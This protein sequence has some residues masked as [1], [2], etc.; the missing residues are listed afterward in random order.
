MSTKSP[1]FPVS[2]CVWFGF[3]SRR[4]VSSFLCFIVVAATFVACEL[5][6]VKPSTSAPRGADSSQ[7]F[8][9]ACSERERAIDDWE[10]RKGEAVA[11]DFIDGKITLLRAGLEA[12]R[13][14]EEADAMRRKLRDNCE[15][16]AAA[17][18][19]R[20][21]SSRSSSFQALVS[22]STPEPS[23]TP[24]LA[25]IP[26]RTPTPMERANLNAAECIASGRTVDGDKN[27]EIIVEQSGAAFVKAGWYSDPSG[28]ER[29]SGG[30]I[31]VPPETPKYYRYWKYEPDLASGTFTCQETSFREYPHT[32]VLA[33]P[34]DPARVNEVAG[35][36]DEICRHWIKSWHDGETFLDTRS[37]KY[38]NS[39]GQGIRRQFSVTQTRP[40]DERFALV[41]AE[42]KYRFQLAPRPIG[43]R[44]T[45]GDWRT[46]PIYMVYDLSDNTCR[47]T[48]HSATV[49]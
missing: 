41:L 21:Q 46:E 44:A 22:T 48:E 42:H 11:E 12:E 17:D 7:E 6:P 28:A 26:T 9:E 20:W 34:G 16:K 10:E 33:A 25:P 38:Q 43:G 39:G 13:I 8:W 2:P 36:A 19:P 30:T 24:M 49:W 23:P 4:F 18:F 45:W 27:E 5:I 29:V 3:G 32:I 35:L 40:V 37:R 31:T 15:A 14:A 47:E 1:V